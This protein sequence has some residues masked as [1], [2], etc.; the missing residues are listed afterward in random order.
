MNC[1]RI[2]FSMAFVSLAL[3]SH[4]RAHQGQSVARGTEIWS[5]GS[6]RTTCSS[7]ISIQRPEEIQRLLHLRL[8]QA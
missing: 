1:K 4:R 7:G 2:V 8:R 5:R 6:W 3:D